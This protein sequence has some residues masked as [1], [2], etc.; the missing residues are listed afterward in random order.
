ML[1]RA[2]VRSLRSCASRSCKP[3]FSVAENLLQESMFG[4]AGTNN[5]RIEFRAAYSV[6]SL[7]HQSQPGVLPSNL[8]S[9]S[10]QMLLQR[11]S[12]DDDGT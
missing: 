3:R 6:L 10:L 5:I 9:T 1:S 12:P 2:A 4:Q 8:L 7:L 11:T